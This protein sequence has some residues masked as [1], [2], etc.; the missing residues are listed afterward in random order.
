MTRWQLKLGRL[1]LPPVVI[2]IKPDTGAGETDLAI[3]KGYFAGRLKFS[4][5]LVQKNAFCS[6]RLV[7]PTK[8]C[9]AFEVDLLLTNSTDTLRFK[10]CRF[11]FEVGLGNQFNRRYAAESPVLLSV[12]W[13]GKEDRQQAAEKKNSG[14]ASLNQNVTR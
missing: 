1:E 12:Y 9:T 5:L 8:R 7:G 3:L 11:K 4:V 2:V 13:I 6:N 14:Y 10:L